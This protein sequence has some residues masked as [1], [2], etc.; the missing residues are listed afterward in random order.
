MPNFKSNIIIAPVVERKRATYKVTFIIKDGGEFTIFQGKEE[1]E[2]TEDV[3]GKGIPFTK[4]EFPGAGDINATPYVWDGVTFGYN[5]KI[6]TAARLKAEEK[7]F[8]EDITLMLMTEIGEYKVTFFRMDG[9]YYDRVSNELEYLVNYPDFKFTEN[10]PRVDLG[11]EES[12]KYMDRLYRFTDKWDIYKNDNSTNWYTNNFFKTMTT[13]E[14]KNY[15]IDNELGVYPN[16][17]KK[18]IDV[19]FEEGGIDYTYPRELEKHQKL[20]VEK[21]G[22]KAISISKI[23][24]PNTVITAEGVTTW[25]GKRWIIRIEGKTDTLTGTKEELSAKTF[26]NKL[27]IKPVVS[28]LPPPGH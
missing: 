18:D 7:T 1:Q 5:E 12:T 25:E 8:N 16:L 15:K 27:Y 4:V 19:V 2:F 17:K 22:D 3:S 24:F 28:H 20:Q 13:D 6:T 9:V 26:D 11:L 21:I 23:K 10:L 14:F